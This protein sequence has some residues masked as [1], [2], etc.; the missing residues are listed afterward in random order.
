MPEQLCQANFIEFHDFVRYEKK[1]ERSY[2]CVTPGDPPPLSLVS[3][4]SRGGAPNLTDNDFLG[5]LSSNHT[6]FKSMPTS[7]EHMGR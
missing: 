7:A 1:R 6:A 3:A 4:R 5:S 2:N